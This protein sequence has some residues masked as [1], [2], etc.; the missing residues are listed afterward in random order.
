MNPDTNFES[1]SFNLFSTK[2]SFSNNEQNSIANFYHDV[3]MLDIQ[4]FTLGKFET[5]FQDYSK[6]YFSV[7]HFNIGCVNQNFESFREI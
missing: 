3:S 2:E 4:Y 5:N 1:T 7:F 6:K